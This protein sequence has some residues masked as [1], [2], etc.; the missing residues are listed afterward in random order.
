MIWKMI[1]GKGMDDGAAP[2]PRCCVRPALTIHLVSFLVLVLLLLLTVEDVEL[3]WG[4]V[5]L[6]WGKGR[7]GLT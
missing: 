5:R 7:R 4:V 1:R 6:G 2:L 3:S